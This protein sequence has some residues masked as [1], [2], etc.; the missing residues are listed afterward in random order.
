MKKG[1]RG[2]KKRYEEKKPR[3]L[4]KQNK[5]PGFPSFLFQ[6]SSDV[7]KCHSSGR[8]VDLAVFLFFYLFPTI[9]SFP[10]FSFNFKKNC[11]IQWN[12]DIT[13]LYTEYNEVLDITNDF[14][15][16]TDSKMYEKRTSLTKPRYCEHILPVPWPFVMS[17]EVLL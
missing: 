1:T 6:L 3:H 15:Y 12:L 17:V 2:G 10:F 9:T 4:N 8:I 7:I 5:T 13:N 16:P 14:L 11:I